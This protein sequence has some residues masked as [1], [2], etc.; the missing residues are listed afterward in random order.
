MH[1]WA[2]GGMAQFIA[3]KNGLSCKS[4]ICHL[5][6][7]FYF[8]VAECGGTLFS[9]SQLVAFEWR[10]LQVHWKFIYAIVLT[11]IYIKHSSGSVNSDA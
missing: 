4:L 8:C 9:N 11:L 7:C 1:S 3:G 10:Q 6:L 5:T 2:P